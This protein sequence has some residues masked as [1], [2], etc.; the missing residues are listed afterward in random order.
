MSIPQD[1]ADELLRFGE[2]SILVRVRMCKSEGLFYLRNFVERLTES[3]ALFDQWYPRLIAFAA[4]KRQAHPFPSE[5]ALSDFD[6]AVRRIVASKVPI[7]EH[8]PARPFRSATIFTAPLVALEVVQSGWPGQPPNA[9][10]LTPDE[11]R[12]WDEVY[13]HPES[14]FWWFCFQ[15]WNVDFDPLD[16]TH[17]A[18]GRSSPRSRRRDTLAVTHGLLWGSQAGERTR[19]YGPG[20]DSPSVF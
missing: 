2:E 15:W 5:H 11:L 20:M 1:L 18:F 17:L 3:A 14:A 13:S 9:V 10:F 6:R 8:A 16:R 4:T 7:A 19:N 12:E